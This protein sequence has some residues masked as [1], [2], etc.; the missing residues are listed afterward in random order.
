[1]SIG[2]K[3]PV[4]SRG[5]AVGG[6][7]GLKRPAHAALGPGRQGTVKAAAGRG[8]SKSVNAAFAESSS[9]DE[10]S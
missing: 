4:S 6:L 2:L 9:E 8:T 1:L 5:G 3:R 10:G 7:S